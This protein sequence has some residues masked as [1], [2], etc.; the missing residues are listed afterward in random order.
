MI[1]KS[2][3][4]KRLINKKQRYIKISKLAQNPDLHKD[5]MT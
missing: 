1:N 2:F 3:E 4:H 5:K